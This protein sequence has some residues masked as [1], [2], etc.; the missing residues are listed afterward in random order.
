M[1]VNPVS[2]Y[3]VCYSILNSDMREFAK[4]AMFSEVVVHYYECDRALRFSDELCY[5]SIGNADLRSF[6]VA[7][8]FVARLAVDSFLS[9]F[10]SNVR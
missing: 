3:V 8:E 7:H 9:E 5:L 2:K 4:L 1:S 6:V 10:G